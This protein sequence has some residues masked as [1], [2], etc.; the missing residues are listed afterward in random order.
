MGATGNFDVLCGC[1]G[2]GG[3]VVGGGAVGW[4]GFEFFFWGLVHCRKASPWGVFCMGWGIGIAVGDNVVVGWESVALGSKRG[5]RCWWLQV[6]Y[7]TVWRFLFSV[8]PV[9]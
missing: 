7:Q 6:F 5:L 4:L 9:P 1:G 8:D 3:F 2:S